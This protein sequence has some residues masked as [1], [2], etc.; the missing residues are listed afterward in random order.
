MHTLTE[1]NPLLPKALLPVA[2]R[3]LLAWV[4]AWL[5]R[6]GVAR[7]L[8][9]CQPGQ[10]GPIGDWVAKIYQ[11]PA[12]AA[13]SRGGSAGGVDGPG[14]GDAGRGDGVGSSCAGVNSGNMRRCASEDDDAGGAGARVEVVATA[15]A[16]DGTAA[17]LRQLRDRIDV[18]AR[19]NLS[20]IDHADDFRRRTSL[21][22]R[23]IC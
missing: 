12:A 13:S 2:N 14:V 16:Y 9:A 15:G 17:V 20:V 7:I 19:L 6:A 8:V 11:G 3:P 23:A 18:R 5:E 10:A 1:H 21:W 4:L 22:C